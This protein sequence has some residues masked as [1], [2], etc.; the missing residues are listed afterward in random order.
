MADEDPQNK[1][2]PASEQKLRKARKEG[3]GVR[4]KDLGH[5][6]VMLAAGGMLIGL[7]PVWL[8]HM[9]TLMR[10]A[11]HFD[12]RSV[13]MD[14]VMLERLSAWSVQ[15]LWVVIPLG[16][17]LVVA[18][19]AAAIGAGGWMMSFKVIEPKFSKLNPIEGFGRVFSK[20]Q[21]VDALKASLMALLIGGVGATVLWQHWMELV[22]LM[23]Q[24]LPAA[25][26]EMG[27]SLSR[28]W[29]AI[30]IVLG[31]FAMIDWPWQRFNFMQRQ[32]MDHKE[33][34]DEHKQQEGSPEVKA[35]LRQRMREMSRKRMLAAVPTADLI[36]MNPSHYAVALKYDEATMNAPR[37]VA[38]GLD[39]VAFRIRDLAREH[40][41]P[42]LEAPP[43]ARALYANCEVDR[44]VPMALY[45]AVAQVLAYV[46]QL[47]AAMTGRGPMPK[48]MPDLPV[49]AELDPLNKPRSHMDVADQETDV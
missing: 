30:L 3:Q 2:L 39:L 37:V 21:F 28:V 26:S 4:S 18:A 25:I 45:S 27:R 17:A 32:R 8:E 35:Q 12:A 23:S 47:K 1:P 10:D 19:F 31:I 11:L 7:M 43:L 33:V 49:P 24:E 38:K 34:K 9:R 16:L 42:V 14:G 36:V 29:W 46:Y 6:L 13:A 22:Q 15:A 40:K 44:E 41:V 48:Q 20:Q 5:F